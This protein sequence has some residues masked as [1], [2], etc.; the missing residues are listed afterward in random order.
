MLS[1][2]LQGF[3]RSSLCDSAG[4]KTPLNGVVSSLTVLVLFFCVTPALYYLPS[5]VL[6][7]MIVMAVAGLIDF[8]GARDLW[9]KDKRDFLTMLAA[10]VATLM[11]GVMVR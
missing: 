9:L 10:L 7:A 1:A 8:R 4:A 5:C 3:S 6:G 2:T 11:L